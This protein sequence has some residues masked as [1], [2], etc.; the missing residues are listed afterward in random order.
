MKEE[1]LKKFV[2]EK[3]SE[4]ARTKNSGCCSTPSCCGGE[5]EAQTKKVGYSGEELE[6]IPQEA[7]KGLGC[8]N[9]VNFVDLEEGE[10][11]LD[12]GSGMGIDVFLASER[13]GSEGLAVGMDASEEMVRKANRIAKR[14]GYD[15]VEF[16]RGE[17]EELP[18]E[19]ESFD[20]VISN[21]VINL[22]TDKLKTYREIYRVLKPNGRILISDIVTDGQLPEKIRSD[23]EVWASCIGGALQKE[24]Y[25][26]TIK[27]AGFGE[28]EVL[29]QDI[30]DEIEG[31]DTKIMSLQVKAE[32]LT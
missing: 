22:S 24:D 12:L 10:R 23:P 17:M 14:R 1:E 4:I 15:N 26:N 2:K 28:I 25:L 3:Y 9:P 29:S 7:I 32:K 27:E 13:V 6:K 18:F 5:P 11:V 16:R 8:G 21:C 30:F 31:V 20:V 19:G